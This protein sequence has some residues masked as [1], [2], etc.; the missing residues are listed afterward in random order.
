MG[1]V[2]KA[3]DL[4]LKRSVAL[5]FLR[6]GQVESTDARQRRQ[7]ERDARAQARFE[8][9]NICKIYEV[10][11]VEGQPYIAM[12]IIQGSSLSGLQEVMS[13]EE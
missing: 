9:P 5:K 2:Y 1:T 11:E 6:G 13:R 3:V 7:F 8:H 4:R 10:G 12:Q